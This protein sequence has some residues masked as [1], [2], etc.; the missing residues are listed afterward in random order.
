[1]AQHNKAN[2][3]KP[4]EEDLVLYYY[5]ELGG[6]ER[7]AVESHLP[8]CQLCRLYLKELET[9]L[10]LTVKPDAPPQS[11]WDDYSREMRGKIAEASER[12][13]WWQ[14]LALFSSPWAIPAS[15][16]ALVALLALSLTFGKAFWTSKEVPRDDAA[17]MEI[18]PMAENLEFFETME[19]LDTMDLLENMAISGTGSV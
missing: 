4:F 16:T 17:F 13:S 5:G 2:A 8:V 15:A 11:F 1:M 10:P 7:T 3:C 6:N 9:I 18:L 12:R 19:V 14:T